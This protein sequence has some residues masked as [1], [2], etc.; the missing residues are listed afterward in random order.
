MKA[1]VVYDSFFGNTAKIAET[2]G[3]TLEKKYEVHAI[4]VNQL[5]KV[6]LK[7]AQLLIVGS[8]TRA[9]EPTKPIVS[10][11]RP[12]KAA[13]YPSL[14]VAFFDTRM[15]VKKVNNKV[16]NFFVKFRGY[17]LDTMEKIGKKSGFSSAH[18]GIGFIVEDSEGPLADGEIEKAV[19][20]SN[21]LLERSLA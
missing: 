12:L 10:F 21:D 3:S 16:L 13:D 20:W 2:I 15:D 14:K 6:D 1:V 5:N 9:F 19:Q 18:L 17:A 11:L 4:S 8:P 7:H